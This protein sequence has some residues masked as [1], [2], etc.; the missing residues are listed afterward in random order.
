MLG[1]TETSGAK[2]LIWERVLFLKCTRPHQG[3]PL[4][5]Q[6]ERPSLPCPGQFLGK[7]TWQIHL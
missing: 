1:A 7:A 3:V 2:G 6:K 5:K 4:G